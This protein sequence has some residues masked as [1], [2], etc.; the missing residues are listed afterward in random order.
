MAF[1][2]DE[3]VEMEQLNNIVGE[4]LKGFKDES[5]YFLPDKVGQWTQAIIDT[6]LKELV[7]MNK[8]YKYVVT[9]IIQQRLGAG[10][11]TVT[12]MHWDK[13]TDGLTTAQL[14]ATNLTLIVTVFYMH[15]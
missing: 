11:Q 8:P 12:A 10:L 13:K 2:P 7:K 1:D 3:E 6:C 4:S 9:C 15:I 5:V 14:D